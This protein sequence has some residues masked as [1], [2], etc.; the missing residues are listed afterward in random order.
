MSPRIAVAETL[1][2]VETYVKEFERKRHSL[3]HEIDGVVV[4]VDEIAVQQRLG[5]TSR[6]PRWAIAVKYP[7]KSCGPDCWISRSTSAARAG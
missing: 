4:K 2:E 1:D 5:S 6:A 3:D 7:R